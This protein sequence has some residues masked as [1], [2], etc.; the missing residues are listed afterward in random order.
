[1]R[2]VVVPFFQI[3]AADLLTPTSMAASR[4]GT[5]WASNSKNR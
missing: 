2:C 1:L 4:N 5:P 3:C